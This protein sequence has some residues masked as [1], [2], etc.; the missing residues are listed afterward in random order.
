MGAKLN[1]PWTDHIQL[2]GSMTDGEVAELLSCTASAAKAARQRLGIPAHNRVPWTQEDDTLLSNGFI[3]CTVCSL[4]KST[5]EYHPADRTISGLRRTCSPCKNKRSKERM[6]AIKDRAAS[7]LGGCC[8]NCGYDQ[9][10]SALQFHH[11]FGDEKKEMISRMM[12][13]K[14]SASDFAKEIDKCCLL[15]SNCHDAYHGGDLS[16]VFVKNSLGYSVI[17]E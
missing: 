14:T 8:S 12:S 2:L 9:C 6:R 17:K 16:L 13:Q 7:L 4:T 1:I 3:R 10:Q 11:V 5:S 15:C